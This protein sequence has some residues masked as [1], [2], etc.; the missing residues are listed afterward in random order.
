MILGI[1]PGKKGAL[2]LYDPATG[3]L[4]V[5]DVPVLDIRGRAQ[6]DRYALAE[7]T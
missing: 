6:V 1:D 2:A 3:D 4:Q 5:E 7:E